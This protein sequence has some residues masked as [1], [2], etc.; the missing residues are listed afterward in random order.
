MG[1]M[2]Y[3]DRPLTPPPTGWYVQALGTLYQPLASGPQV[4]VLWGIKS[5]A[6]PP[7]WPIN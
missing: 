2:E 4:A 5:L 3:R 6:T 1:D 7:K